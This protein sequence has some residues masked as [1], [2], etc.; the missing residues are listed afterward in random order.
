MD[1]VR[2]SDDQ[3][4]QVLQDSFTTWSSY[5]NGEDG[6]LPRHAIEL[7]HLVNQTPPFLG[8]LAPL[9]GATSF[10]C[11]EK[12]GLVVSGRS[13]WR[14]SKGNCDSEPKL[15]P[16]ELLLAVGRR[17]N[18]TL[19]DEA[20]FS[21][22]PGV[23][24]LSGYDQSNQLSVLYIAWAYILSARWVE[25]L[26]R[27]ADHECCMAYSK[28]ENPSPQLDKPSIVDIGD[29]GEEEAFWWRAILSDDWDATTK[30]KDREYLSP[31]SVSAKDTGL[32]LP[33]GVLGAESN[34]P[35][36]DTALKYLS[37]FC[38]HHRLYAQCSV[39]LAGVL[40]IPFLRKKIVSLPFPRCVRHEREGVADDFDVPITKALDDHSE[41]LSNYMTL[42]SNEWG[43]R[44]LLQSTFF[45]PDIDCNLVSA[46]LN[47]AFAILK[48][49]QSKTSIAAFLAN[50]N[51]RL[52]SLWLGAILTGLADSVLRD[53]RSGM[54]ALDLTASGWT[55]ISQSFLTSKMEKSHGGLL[56][57]DDESRLLYI[58]A[59]EGHDRPPL[60]PFKPFGFTR[61]EDTELMVRKHAQCADH[62]LEYESWE[63]ILTNG[64][65]IVNSEVQTSQLVR[66]P[67]PSANGVS[68]SAGIRDYDYDFDSQD[69]SEGFT[70]GIFGW[71]RSTGYPEHERPIYQHSWFDLEDPDDDEPDDADSDLEIQQ[72]PKK[73]HVEKWL[74][75]IE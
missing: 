32:V 65:S 20:P 54:I 21:V 5:H 42:S 53:I 63:W 45:N 52:G 10:A 71:L 38:I 6:Q 4:S 2:P 64:R 39:A 40:Y 73:N 26:A 57:R 41:L 55:G 70:Y 59:S 22:W 12:G 31:W 25:L 24:G 23:R 30:Y 1:A 58:L 67:V 9:N 51:P 47:P 43:L 34:P 33:T 44:S 46:W 28:P 11:E 15:M 16:K 72:T 66:T 27:S 49:I 8:G 36:S 7:N 14:T 75:G 18:V 35:D 17:L 50:R 60:W 56:R 13:T 69:L 3:F 68:T 48:S 19:S 62:C 61:L 74:G 29:S 37:R